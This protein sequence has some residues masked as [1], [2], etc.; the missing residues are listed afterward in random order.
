M[1]TNYNKLLVSVRAPPPP[2][3]R[4]KNL[5]LCRLFPL[6]RFSFFC[7]SRG[8]VIGS[9]ILSRPAPRPMPSNRVILSPAMIDP[10]CSTCLPGPHDESMASPSDPL[11][12]SLL[13]LTVRL[14]L[15][16]LLHTYTYCTLD[17]VYMFIRALCP[18]SS[19]H[20]P[21]G[22]I[23]HSINTPFLSLS[24]LQSCTT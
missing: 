6:F 16:A 22:Y 24:P 3:T 13:S 8:V 12:Y 7:G 10:P 18:Y 5:P 1:H 2:A 20:Y 21:I 15:A 14:D 17:C 19:T 23:S 9:A 11:L 4:L